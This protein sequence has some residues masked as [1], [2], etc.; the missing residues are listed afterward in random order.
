MSEALIA[1]PFR[2]LHLSASIRNSLFVK[3]LY[4]SVKITFIV[5]IRHC[6]LL[7]LIA[8]PRYKLAK[9]IYQCHSIPTCPIIQ[10]IETHPI[11]PARLINPRRNNRTNQISLTTAIR[12][13]TNKRYIKSVTRMLTHIQRAS[14]H[15]LGKKA[16]R[17]NTQM[18]YLIRWT[19]ILLVLRP[20][21]GNVELLFP[22]SLHFANI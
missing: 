1:S 22:Q 18:K 11:S 15:P 2:L 4:L 17:F 10:P 14:I 6:H 13:I 3:P 20:R 5:N 12:K 21:V 8:T 19:L 9:T 16:R 7:P